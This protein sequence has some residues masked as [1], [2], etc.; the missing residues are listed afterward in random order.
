MVHLGDSYEREADR[1][2]EAQSGDD[3][4]GSWSDSDTGSSS[5]YVDTDVFFYDTGAEAMSVPHDKV[6]E[7]DIDEW[8]SRDVSM[9]NGRGGII[10]RADGMAAMGIGGGGVMND[11]LPEGASAGERA[12]AVAGMGWEGMMR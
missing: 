5:D 2:E 3:S 8:L 10:E 6:D 4:E 7:G 11:G 12:M 1:E 9:A